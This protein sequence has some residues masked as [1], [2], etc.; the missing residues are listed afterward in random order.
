MEG[1]RPCLEDGAAGFSDCFE[2]RNARLEAGD[3]G[4]WLD[5]DRPDGYLLGSYRITTVP[6]PSS[7][8]LTSFKSTCFDSPAN[9]VGPWPASLVHH[10]LVLIDQSQLRQ[11]Q[12]EL[13]ASHEQSLARLPLQ[14]LNGLSQLIPAH[15]LRVP[16]DPVQGTRHDILL[17]RVDRPGEGFHPIAH[18][19]RP[20][21]RPGHRP[22]PCLHN[23]IGCPA[24]EKGIRLCKVLGRVT[25]QLFIRDH[26]AVIAAPIQ[27]DIDGIPKGSHRASLPRSELDWKVGGTV[28]PTYRS[29]IDLTGQQW[30]IVQKSFN[31]RFGSWPCDSA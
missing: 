26:R 4:N 3:T 5:R 7:S 21:S 22:P 14:L 25:M 20:H 8:R 31:V 13:H 11:R 23:F 10:E 27:S 28:D 19:I 30:T 18:P 16:I 2:M 15:D 24:K 1:E 17:C 12:L 29:G 6:E 9:N